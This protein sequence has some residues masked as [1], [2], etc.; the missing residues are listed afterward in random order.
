MMTKYRFVFKWIPILVLI[1]GSYSLAAIPPK[2]EVAILVSTGLAKYQVLEK[3]LNIPVK[4]QS[5]ENYDLPAENT[6]FI[7]KIFKPMGSKVSRGEKI[8][9]L[10]HP[11]GQYQDYFLRSPITGIV[12]NFTKSVGSRVL[13]DEIIL[14][15]VRENKLKI[16]GFVPQAEMA[17]VQKGARVK[18]KDDLTTDW[19]VSAIANNVNPNTGGFLVEFQHRGKSSLRD[20]MV[21]SAEVVLPAPKGIAVD[22]QAIVKKENK[23]LI[24]T[25]DAKNKV[26]FKDV[27]LGEKI[28]KTQ[29]IKKGLENGDKVVLTSA[30]FL[31]DG[32]LVFEKELTEN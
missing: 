11:S 7:T 15:V 12:S 22:I 30:D 31:K 20:G 13:R 9:R 29:L 17:Q 5:L 16:L 25:I 23:Y 4:V 6:G 3:T 21:V 24:R 18:I 26:T 14:S 27:V 1:A 2:E 32:D 8:L 28:G 10:R 19:Y